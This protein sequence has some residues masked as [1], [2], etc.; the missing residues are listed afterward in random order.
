MPTNFLEATG[1]LTSPFTVMSSELSSLANG[2]SAVSSVN[3]TSGVF[4]QASQGSGIWGTVNFVAGGAFTPTAGG[5]LAGWFTFS[6]DG[7]VFEKVVSNTDLPRPPDFIVP[8]FV[9]A[10][11]ANDVQQASGLVR[12]PWWSY[13]VFVVNR[14]GAALPSSNNL[15]KLS[16]V[17]VQY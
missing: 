16:S 9:S 6:P 13:K 8:L 15:I 3:G 17:A 4:T 12:L 14:S 5:Y 1:F 2:N 7:T 10:Y 11:S